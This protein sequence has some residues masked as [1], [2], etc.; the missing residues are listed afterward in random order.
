MRTERAGAELVIDLD[1]IAANWRAL[2]DRVAP[3]VGSAAVVKADAYGL[4]VGPVAR[5]LAAAG[6]TA[7]FVA[8]PDEGAALRRVVPEAT[9]LVLHGVPPRAEGF[10]ARHRLVPVV[11]DLGELERWR[12]RAATAGG[13]DAVLHLDTGLNRLGIP[14]EDSQRLIDRPE[15]V[16]GLRVTW[17]SHLACADEPGH[18]MNAEQL[19]RFRVLLGRLPAGPATLAASAGVLL[20]PAYHFDLVRPGY[21]LYGGNPVAGA[22]AMRPVVRLSARILQVRRVDTPGSVGY[23]AA[24]RVTGARNIATVPVGYADGFLRSLGGR[25]S[26]VIDGWRAPVVGRISMDL[27]TIDVSGIPSE[28]ARPGAVVELIGETRTVEAVA[29]DAGTIGYEILTALGR[30]YPRHYVGGTVA[31]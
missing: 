8:T 1:A 31:A 16:R 5:A 17:M 7:F 2:R 20:G 9:I 14:P 21:A 3:G 30:R 19:R 18:P 27:T 12:R 10:L 23:G 25:G 15:L 29:T 4:G 22:P 26:A 28:R 11:N 6:C 13:G 24:H